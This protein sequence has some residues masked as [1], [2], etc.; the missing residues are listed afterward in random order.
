M[1]SNEPT[2]GKAAVNAQTFENA[3]G[4]YMQMRRQREATK[5][6][7]DKAWMKFTTAEVALAENAHVPLRR[8]AYDNA[9]AEYLSAK[10]S[11]E[12]AVQN[13]HEAAM[14]YAAITACQRLGLEATNIA[15][16]PTASPCRLKCSK[17]ASEALTL[18]G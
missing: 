1:H 14:V 3:C 8:Q 12:N 9:W 4:T 16:P 11:F 6:S 10:L 13:C 17:L 5:K 7:L 2:H 18:H 15:T